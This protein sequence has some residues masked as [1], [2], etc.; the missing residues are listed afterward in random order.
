MRIRALPFSKEVGE[1]IQAHKT[2]YVIE[3]NRDGQLHQILT[4]EYCDLTHRLTSLAYIDGLPMTAGYIIDA[5]S[6]REGVK[7]G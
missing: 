6:E 2:N 7:H 1:F 4:I 3:L 5:V